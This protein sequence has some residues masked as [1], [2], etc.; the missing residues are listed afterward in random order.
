MR[1]KFLTNLFLLL[2]LNLLIKLFWIFKI[3][4][5]VQDIVGPASYGFYFSILNFSFIFQILLDLGIT[6]YNN[7]NIAQ[8]THLLNKYFSS[9]IILRF[10]FAALYMLVIMGVGLMIG[11]NTQQLYLLFV[12]GVNQFLLSL[13]L[14]LRSNISALLLFKTD[15]IISVL[16]RFFMILICSVLIWGNLNLGEFAIEWFVYAQTASYLLTAGIAWF[17][18]V[19]K[20]K[21]LKFNWNLSF[22]MLILKQSLPYALLI[23]LMGLYNR[24]DSVF[25][26]RMLGEEGELQSGIYASAFRLLDAANNMSGFLFAGLLLPIFARLLK[27]KE[28]VSSM[29]KLSFTLLFIASVGV[30][31]TSVFYGK[32]IMQLLYHQHSKESLSD[33]LMRIQQTSQIFTVLMF[34]YISIST[35]YIFG[36]LLTANGSLKSL[37]RMAFIGVIISIL[38]NVFLI[39]EIKA[40][41]SAYASLMAQTFTAIAQV[42]LAYKIVGFR[43]EKSYLLHLLFFIIS[44]ILINIL[45]SG[46]DLDWKYKLMLVVLSV[47]LSAFVL[48]LLNLKA[49]FA[50][51]KNEKG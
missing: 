26:E 22:F 24:A 25:I 30:A 13:I 51:L 47:T 2:F 32:D 48:R 50:I 9:I 34:S 33:Y 31:V 44:V 16:D 37:N 45:F 3:D 40:M 43:V 1:K 41:G 5:K 12:I 29:V 11:Y 23:L 28:D 14:Y 4:I 46:F 10:L 49:F 20:A 21:F 35:T 15:S 17:V 36:T 38:L 6:N 19:R 39:P 42:W 18:V 7:K 8:N 27:Q